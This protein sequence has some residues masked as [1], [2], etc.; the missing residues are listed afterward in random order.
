MPAQTVAQIRQRFGA[1]FF[2]EGF[3][4]AF[5]LCT[6]FRAALWTEGFELPSSV[7]AAIVLSPEGDVW[8]DRLLNQVQ[9]LTQ[10]E[11]R[12]AVFLD[13]YQQELLVDPAKTDSKAIE[14]FLSSELQSGRMRFPWIGDHLLYERFFDQ[15]RRQTDTLSIAETQALIVDTPQGVFQLSDI[16]IGPYGSLRSAERRFMPPIRSV[17]L[18]HCSDPTCNASH[19]VRLSSVQGSV[20]AGAEWINFQAQAESPGLSAWPDYFRTHLSAATFYDDFNTASFPYFLIDAFSEAEARLILS[21]VIQDN[22]TELRETLSL[23]GIEGVRSKSPDEITQPLSKP[24]CVQLLLTRNTQ[25]L[26]AAIDRLVYSRHIGIPATETRTSEENYVRRGWYDVAVECSNH[27][28]RF[29]SGRENVTVARTK[30]LLKSVYQSSASS[31]EWR[32]RFVKGSSLDQKLDTYVMAEDPAAVVRDAVFS[33]PEGVKATFETL[34]FGWLPTPVTEAEERAFVSMLLWKL[35][36]DV[37]TYPDYQPLYWQRLSKFREVAASADSRTEA[38]REA[39]RSAA[40][41]LW[42]SLEEVLDYTLSFV[43]WALVGDAVAQTFRFELT[44]ARAVMA[45]A[46]AG[47]DGQFGPLAFDRSGRNTLNPL[48]QGFAALTSLCAELRKA[49]PQ[50]RRPA[51]E[52]PGYVNK[53]DVQ[54]YPF[55]HTKLLFDLD[56]FDLEAALKSFTSVTQEFDRVSLYDLRN[57]IEHKRPDFP[58]RDE[59]HRLCESLANVVEMLESHGYCPAVSYAA[60]MSQDSY[61]RA[62][63]LYRDYQERVLEI[64]QPSALDASQMPTADGSMVIVSALRVIGTTE[65]LRFTYYE[66]SDYTL[67]QTDY[68]RRLGVSALDQGVKDADEAS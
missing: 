18:F 63:V 48:G 40:V 28:I 44:Q 67:L 56:P 64:R 23:A 12:F 25:D 1:Q 58:D 37:P 7:A 24:Q 62:V 3:G 21:Q 36:Y 61:G 47:R 16:L 43:T 20:V 57:R 52:L 46:L 19:Q 41:N 9:G 29:E 15:V 38:G 8:S 65:P 50:Y 53:T 42:V 10:A 59:T 68:P 30:R 4:H 13:F 34:R 22:Q 45:A 2:E 60:S 32:L 17:V 26:V 49:E 54:L 39:I 55:T 5:A 31:L 27:G 35:G 33:T 51:T 11:S 66:P 14:A 6:L